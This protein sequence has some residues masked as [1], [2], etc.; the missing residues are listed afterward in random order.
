MRT[1]DGEHG[2]Q[3][4]RRDGWTGEVD[5]L[6]E[7]H[8]QQGAPRGVGLASIGLIE[9]RRRNGGPG[10]P[11]T[12]ERRYCITSLSADGPEAVR[13]FAGAVRGHW[14]IENGLHWVLDLSFRED[15]SRIR[16]DHAAENLATVR[17]LAFNLLGRERTAKV[18]I[19]AKRLKAGWDDRYLER[20]LTI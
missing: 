3:E 12:V 17:H 1:G 10:I 7:R 8:Q 2:R 4:T 11:E 16:K 5:W 6:G 14:G 15:E 18:G 13:R 19:K 20:L 9:S